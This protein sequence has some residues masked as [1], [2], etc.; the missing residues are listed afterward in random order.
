MDSPFHHR[1][2]MDVRRDGP[3]NGQRSHSV[4]RDRLG[5]FPLRE[6]LAHQ[7]G[8]LR[9]DHRGRPVRKHR[10]QVGKAQRHPRDPADLLRGKRPMRDMHRI[11]DAHSLPLHNRIRT[12]RRASNRIHDGHRDVPRPLP[13][14]ERGP[15]GELLGLGMDRRLDGRVPR[16]PRLRMA[17]G[18]LRRS[19]SSPVRGRP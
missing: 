19:P 10:G 18:V 14:Q 2:G 6:E 16:D 17:C 9:Y 8:H 15:A 1:A 5:P 3:G 7:L 4:H 13:R 12:G 11:L